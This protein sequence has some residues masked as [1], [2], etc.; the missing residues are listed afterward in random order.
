LIGRHNKDVSKDTLI[1]TCKD[2]FI[3][4]IL[5]LL[6]EL[7]CYIYLVYCSLSELQLYILRV[8]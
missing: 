6:I 8:E 1:L 4:K 2:D 7:L 5:K 3:N